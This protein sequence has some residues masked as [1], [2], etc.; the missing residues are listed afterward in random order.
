[1]PTGDIHA[2]LGK[3]GLPMPVAEL[4]ARDWDA[5]VVGGGHNGLTTAAY[6]AKSGKSVLV[7]EARE[8]LGGACTLETPFTDD[9]YRVSPCAYVVGLLDERVITELRLR[10]YGYKVFVA[11]P[12]IWCPFEDGTSYAQFQDP[13]RTAA[14]MRANGFGEAD[15]EGQFA[16][17]DFFDRMRIALRKGPRDAWVGEAPERAELEELLGHDPEMI[18]ALYETPIS[19]VIDRHV[20]DERLKRA[21][22]GQG[23]I[24][25]WAG[26]HDPGTA[27]VKL[28]HFL[29]EL[30]GVPMAWG[31]VEGGMGAISFAIAEAARDLGAVLAADVPVAQIVPGEGVRL[32]GGELIRA[33]VVIS[34]ADPK[35]TLGLL[36]AAAPA[37]F[38]SRVDDWRVTSPV[39]KVNCALSRLPDWA[40]VPGE[41]WPNQAPVTIGQ[42][43][44]DAQRAFEACTRGEVDPAFAEL[45]FHSA[46]DPSVAPAGKHT[47]SA[48]VQYG[49]YD[50]AEG[51][52]DIRRD[53]IGRQVLGMIGEYCD[54]EDCIDEVQV[55]GPPDIE[56]KVGLTAG[57]IFHGECTPDQMWTNRFPTRTTMDGVYL[58]GAATHPAGGVCS[59]NGRNAA[60][61]VLADL[62]AG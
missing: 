29:G 62:D 49:P 33:Q 16:Y 53:E 4:A 18:E 13:E 15:I 5:V 52:W 14:D 40:A 25:A 55:L 6:L 58:C 50:L 34:N 51:T 43:M 26:P 41:I 56:K 60:D 22:Y 3:V 57:H 1:V 28:M 37:A 19:E 12:F 27:F 44:D 54:I 24:G 48:F 7:L 47:L 42:P 46:Y 38:R 35:A 61:A 30:E 9:G 20:S 11:E 10:D 36:G 32:E 59:L 23:I 2:A 45:Y 21:L 31:Y 8:R 39:L 17:E